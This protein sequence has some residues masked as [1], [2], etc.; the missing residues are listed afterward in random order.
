MRTEL[1]ATQHYVGKQHNES[2]SKSGSSV[3][4]AWELANCLQQC[5]QKRHLC[6]KVGSALS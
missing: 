5:S 1:S 3:M 2:E 6:L 4:S